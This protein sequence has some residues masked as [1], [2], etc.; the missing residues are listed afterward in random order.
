MKIQVFDGSVAF[1]EGAISRRMD[2][3]TFLRSRI[4]TTSKVMLVNGP[5]STYKIDPEPGVAGSIT[6]E[7]DRLHQLSLMLRLPSDD[8]GGWSDK[9][10]RER[11]ALHDE[12][13]KSE[14]GKPPY[15]YAWGRVESSI[16]PRDG[17]SDIMLLYAE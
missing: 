1:A 15:R 7:N 11:Q 3:P 12:W 13:L 2:K 8:T 17:F 6:F 5:W 9:A 16:D 14:L 4:G 10:E